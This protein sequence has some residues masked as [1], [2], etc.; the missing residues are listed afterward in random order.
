M[1]LFL[2][3]ITSGSREY[4]NR[5]VEER[6]KKGWTGTRGERVRVKRGGRGHVGA[7]EMGDSGT[8]SV[9]KIERPRRLVL[10]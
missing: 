8:Q 7:C 3:V 10:V 4:R 1:V 6:K 2:C 9:S 5:G